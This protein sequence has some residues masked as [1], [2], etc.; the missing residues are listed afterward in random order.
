MFGDPEPQPADKGV[1][2]LN[3]LWCYLIKDCGRKKACYVCNGSKHMRG[4]VTFAETYCVA[5]SDNISYFWA[6]KAFNNFVTLGTDDANAFNEAPP[7]VDPLYVYCD[8]QYPEC[9]HE[10]KPGNSPIPPALQGHPESLWLWV[11]LIDRIIEKMN[12]KACTQIAKVTLVRTFYFSV[13]YVV[14]DFVILCQDKETCNTII[15]DIHSKMTIDI[16][17]LG[18]NVE[19]TCYGIKLYNLHP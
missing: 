8:K 4:T 3:L 9:Q 11:Q 19:Q 12:L 14:A 1:N 16:T 2:V 13:R 15:E 17:K 10:Q 5:W 6:A 18:V 7:T